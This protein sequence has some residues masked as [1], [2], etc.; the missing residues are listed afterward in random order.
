[1]SRQDR[2]YNICSHSDWRKI[3]LIYKEKLFNKLNYFLRKPSNLRFR[4]PMS[5]SNPSTVRSCGRVFMHMFLLS[6]FHR[7]W[8]NFFKFRSFISNSHYGKN[9][10]IYDVVNLMYSDINNFDRSL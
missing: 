9:R 3:S 4:S 10:G 2:K 1:M 8:F 7:S 5:T 6:M